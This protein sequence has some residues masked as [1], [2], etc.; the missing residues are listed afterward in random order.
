M[1]PAVHHLLRLRLCMPAP[2]TDAA[3]KQLPQLQQA[4]S[5]SSCGT[6]RSLFCAG[7][8][9]NSQ[10]LAAA[11][12]S[13]PAQRQ[14][15]LSFLLAR[16]LT[17]SSVCTQQSS[18]ERIDLAQKVLEQS[19]VLSLVSGQT[20]SLSCKRLQNQ[21]QEWGGLALLALLWV[22]DWQNFVRDTA[23]AD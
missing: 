9:S 1:R 3:L 15:Q 12:A 11:T 7:S 5:S 19:S 4:S 13:G 18:E 16:C 14:Q 23:A 17:S 22:Q 2:A 6:A 8:I 10:G 21:N 20:V